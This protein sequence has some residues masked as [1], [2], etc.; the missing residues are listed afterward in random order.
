MIS[1]RHITA[2]LWIVFLGCGALHAQQRNHIFHSLSLNNDIPGEDY[3]TILQD[4]SG[5]IWLHSSA[6][7]DRFDGQQIKTYH[8]NNGM[9]LDSN[10]ENI[11]SMF[12]GSSEQLFISTTQAIYEYMPQLDAFVHVIKLKDTSDDTTKASISKPSVCKWLFNGTEYFLFDAHNKSILQ[13]IQHSELINS[14][15]PG[16]KGFWP[17]CID[18]NNHFW[19]KPFNKN[20]ICHIACNNSRIEYAAI[21]EGNYR[22]DISFKAHPQVVFQD[23]KGNH[24]LS[25]HGLFFLPKGKEHLQEIDVFSYKT[26]RSFDDFYINCISE[27]KNGDLYIG[28]KN[29]GLIIYHPQKG[30]VKRINQSNGTPSNNINYIYFD[31]KDRTWLFAESKYLCQIGNHYEILEIISANDSRDNALK[32]FRNFMLEDKTGTCWFFKLS[33][34]VQY[35]NPDMARINVMSVSTKG[36]SLRNT[37]YEDKKQQVWVVSGDKLNILQNNRLLPVDAGHHEIGGPI[38]HVRDNEYIIGTGAGIGWFTLDNQKMILRQYHEHN[39]G[40]SNTLAFYGVSHI[41]CDKHDT[42]QVHTLRGYSRFKLPID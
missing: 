32:P 36:R 1:V 9:P 2:F 26:P 13:S 20:A 22:S 34:G 37:V 6:G 14:V 19:I 28:T 25:N 24:W 5:F 35:F 39:M 17:I 40:D 16:D 12:L 23:S 4:S 7:I 15:S 29:H 21:Y 33:G 27:S 30:V 42:V 3:R 8:K 41:F 38:C 11:Q 18:N 31:K 10:D